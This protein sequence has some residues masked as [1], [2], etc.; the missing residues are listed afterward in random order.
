MSAVR[1]GLRDLIG[2]D[3]RAAV[4][5][6]FAA[7]HPPVVA[8]RRPAELLEA[9]GALGYGGLIFRRKNVFDIQSGRRAFVGANA[10]P[11]HDA[12]VTAIG[13]SIAIYWRPGDFLKAIGTFRLFD[14]ISSIYCVLYSLWHAIGNIQGANRLRTGEL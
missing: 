5:A 4:S 6:P 8:H 12:T 13:I 3:A 1:F 11:A 14:H 7:I 10:R 2:A 9:V